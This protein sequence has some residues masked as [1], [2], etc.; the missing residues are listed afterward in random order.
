MH[1]AE[2]GGEQAAKLLKRAVFD[3][4]AKKGLDKHIARLEAHA[5]ANLK[6]LSV[7]IIKQNERSYKSE[8]P[9]AL[10]GFAAGFSN[11]GSSFSLIDVINEEI[12]E[13]R[14]IGMLKIKLHS[15]HM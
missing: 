15:C 14:I 5:Y 1:G 9:R 4:L 10:G 12:V 11:G 6:G 7:E 3:F 8:P 13:S 2:S